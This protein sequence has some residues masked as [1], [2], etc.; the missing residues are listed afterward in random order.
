MTEVETTAAT[1]LTLENERLQRELSARLAELRSCRERMVAVTEVARKEIERNLH[2]GAQQRLVSVAMSL[3]LLDAKL[4]TEPDAAKPIVRE[5][6]ETLAL[7]LRELREL[8]QGLYPSILIE[9][10]LAAALEELADH[11]ALPAKLELSIDTRPPS[12]VETAAYFVVSEALTNAV[13]H[14]HADKVRIVARREQ[15]AVIVEV[16][17]DGI[18]GA[19]RHRGSGLRGLGDRVKALGGRLVVSSPP[20]RGTTVRAAIPCT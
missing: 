4:P 2:D 18:G 13:K 6:R 20:G 9:R 7:T 5:V 16:S 15:A 10:G 14:S 19:A 8:T 17:D 1:E 3:G 12:R 11:T